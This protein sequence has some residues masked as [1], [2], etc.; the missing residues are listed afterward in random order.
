MAK[1]TILIGYY[2]QQDGWH[3][4]TWFPTATEARAWIARVDEAGGHHHA[5]KFRR[6]CGDSNAAM[7]AYDVAEEAH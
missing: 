2:Q 3:I 6:V 5:R 7:H 1:T 4:A